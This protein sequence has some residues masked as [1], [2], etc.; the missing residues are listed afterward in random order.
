[1]RRRKI[2]SNDNV[3]KVPSVN[4]NTLGFEEEIII[5]KEQPQEILEEKPKPVILKE[6]PKE[7]IN[8]QSLNQEV[9]SSINK[10]DKDKFITYKVISY[11]VMPKHLDI[12]DKNFL[13]YSN[14]IKQLSKQNNI[15]SEIIGIPFTR[16]HNARKNAINLFKDQK[17]KVISYFLNRKEDKAIPYFLYIDSNFCLKELPKLKESDVKKDFISINDDDVF[18][19]KNTNKLKKLISEALLKYNTNS[20]RF[21]Y[22]AKNV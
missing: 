8:T 5:E 3:L 1:M 14:H 15:A 22:I 19:I 17:Y 11:I 7:I 4:N 20:D 18:L 10:S 6:K 16:I 9:K 21:K 13:D 12:K 2:K